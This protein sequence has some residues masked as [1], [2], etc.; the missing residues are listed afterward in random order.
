MKNEVTLY[1]CKNKIV[2]NAFNTVVANICLRHDKN[3][4]TSF[5]LTGCEPLVGTTT[6]TVELAISL[7]IAGW[8]TV[9]IDCDMRKKLKYKRISSNIESGLVNYVRGTA[10]KDDIIYP[11]NWE[12]LNYISSGYLVDDDPLKMLYSHNLQ[13]L[14]DELEKEY[15]YVLIDVPSIN[16]SVDS[17]ILS[18]KS[19][20]TILVAS[21]DGAS[22]K[23]L[24][25]ARKKLE[26]E[27]AN[28]IGVIQNK[29]SQKEYKKY[30]KD[31]DYFLKKKYLTQK[32]INEAK[33]KK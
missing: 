8:K 11:T 33:E 23:Y 32:D 24:S 12:N 29:I 26:K 10:D 17:L 25:D 9:I 31:Y 3:N 7:S 13:I 22:N 27:G 15:D 5:L 6:M 2:T 30:T 18:V 16:S 1:R 28:V 14:L 21:L 19:D 4:Y 20:A